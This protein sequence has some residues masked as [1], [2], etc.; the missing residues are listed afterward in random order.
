M[1]HCP[2]V[3]FDCNGLNDLKQKQMARI[4]EEGVTWEFG[5]SCIHIGDICRMTDRFLSPEK[6][7]EDF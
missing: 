4:W 5:D 7:R 2:E 1:P 6:V 3:C